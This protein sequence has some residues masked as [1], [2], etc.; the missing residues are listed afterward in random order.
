VGAKKLQHTSDENFAW[1]PEAKIRTTRGTK[2]NF[3]KTETFFSHPP[4]PYITP[5]NSIKKTYKNITTNS[6]TH[7]I[8]PVF[9]HLTKKMQQYMVARKNGT[10]SKQKISLVSLLLEFF[11][12]RDQANFS[13]HLV[14]L[15]NFS[16][17]E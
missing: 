5:K 8:I 13:G 6:K 17:Q 15:Q 3:V 7:R 11:V 4:G 9:F 16:R 14:P 1:S 10:R 2:W 12:L